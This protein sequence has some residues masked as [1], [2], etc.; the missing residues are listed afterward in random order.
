MHTHTRAMTF[1]ELMLVI[2]ILG[3]LTMVAVPVFRKTFSSLELNTFSRELQ[4]TMHYYTHKALTDAK[5]ITLTIDSEKREYAARIK[6]ETNPFETHAIP[7]TLSIETEHKEINFYPDGTIDKV[8]IV[9]FNAQ[10][11]RIELT[12]KG[13][14]SGVKIK[15]P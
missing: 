12:T 1:I 14:Y 13:V 5:T 11:M 15:S 3:I 7:R 2:L 6:E 8:T 4:S 9:I 10:G